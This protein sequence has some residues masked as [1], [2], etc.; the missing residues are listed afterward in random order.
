MR[1]RYDILY[2]PVLCPLES[3]S[4]RELRNSRVGLETLL[5]TF[6][7]LENSHRL[8]LQKALDDVDT[9]SMPSSSSFLP[10][11]RVYFMWQDMSKEE[12]QEFT[13]IAVEASKYAKK[14]GWRHGLFYYFF[15]LSTT[16]AIL[17]STCLQIC[18]P[19][20]TLTGFQSP[21][22]N[23]MLRK[24]EFFN[25]HQQARQSRWTF[26]FCFVSFMFIICYLQQ[27]NRQ[28]RLY[29]SLICFCCKH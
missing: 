10:P 19:L 12:L 7:I 29:S 24:N 22:K 3:T 17:L 25:L 4:A 6:P 8:A 18:L 1:R 9:M 27:D 11:P 5:N 20:D 28:I 26:L 21:L 16:Y 15:S 2:E 13:R 23:A 14:E